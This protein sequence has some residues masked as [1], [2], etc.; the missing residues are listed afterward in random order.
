MK[1]KINI[2]ILF[3]LLMLVFPLKNIFAYQKVST[4][5]YKDFLRKFLEEK[6]YL[7]KDSD[8][9]SGVCSVGTIQSDCTQVKVSSTGGTYDLD[10]YVAG[11]LS[12]EPGATINGNDEL[13]RA[14]AIIVRSFT[15]A[16]TNDCK[17]TITA[18]SNEQNFNSADMK[19]YKKYAEE[20][21][22]IVMTK[23]DKVIEAVYSLAKAGDC[24]PT[25][26]NKCKFIRCTELAN[27]PSQ[28]TGE[29]TEFIVP[30]G[31]ITYGGSDIHYGGIEPFIA[32]YLANDENYTFDQLL[33][34]FYGE[35]IGL[36]KLSSSKASTDLISSSC[37]SDST[38]SDNEVINKMNKIALQQ[39]KEVHA[40]GQKF[41]SWYGYSYRVEW[42]AIFVSWLFTQVK[43]VNKYIK[44]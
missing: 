39:A 8:N 16:H 22:G 4:T 28:C 24:I 38:V 25:D 31:T 41:W 27:S 37:S 30:K 26:N 21:S 14:W 32:R 23:N 43:G 10:T 9:Q 2:Y 20:T 6:Y 35:N 3:L 12:A 34:A 18:S 5:E 42:C 1:K 19:T 29:K 17:N 13:G 7:N 44:S 40:G 36:A 11:V 33:K 15:I